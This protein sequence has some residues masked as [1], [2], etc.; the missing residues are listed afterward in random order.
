MACGPL[1][2]STETHHPPRRIAA[3]LAHIHQLPDVGVVEREERG[4]R[5]HAPRGVAVVAA[6]GEGGGGGAVEG[7]AVGEEGGAGDKDRIEGAVVEDLLGVVGGLVVGPGGGGGGCGGVGGEEEGGGEG[8]EGGGLE[9]GGGHGGVL[10]SGLMDRFFCC[11]LFLGSSCGSRR[12]IRRLCMCLRMVQGE[13]VD[14]VFIA[15][16]YIGLCNPAQGEGCVMFMEVSG[17]ADSSNSIQ[18]DYRY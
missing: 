5:A 17:R 2:L 3:H 16:V 9:G 12:R 1:A 4:G 13:E 14:W 6:G 18:K 8:E 15:R 7:G 10:E 11:G